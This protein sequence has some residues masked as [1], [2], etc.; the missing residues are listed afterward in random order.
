MTRELSDFT[1]QQDTAG[2]E[3]PGPNYHLPPGRYDEMCG[4]GGSFR[5][6]WR[7]LGAALRDLGHEA[8]LQRARQARRLLRE[9]G[10]TYNVY[11]DP[12]GQSRIWELDPVPMVI[13]SRE[14]SQIESGLMQRA[15]LLD[16]ILA[17]IYG[18]RTLLERG[19]IPPELVFAHPGFLRPCHG[20]EPAGGRRLLLYAADLVRDPGGR[21]TVV[22]DRTQAPSGAGYALENRTV[23]SS[24]LPSL[25][26][27]AQVHRL[28][29]FFQHYRNALAELA[30]NCANEPSI[31]VLTP[32]AR[33]EAYFEHAY[34]AGYL[35]YTL[36][37][38]E[39]LMVGQSQLLLMSPSGPQR[40]DV[41]LR[42]VDD[43]FCDPLELRQESRLGVPGLLQLARA[44]QVGIGNALG[45]SFLENPGLLP[46]LPGIATALL[47][48]D[49]RLPSAATWWCG[50]ARER[51][52]V[53]ANL[54]TL[55]LKRVHRLPGEYPT[56]GW[57]LSRGEAERWK[58]QI[59]AK[60]YLYVG[61]ERLDLSTTPGLGS[62]CLVPQ[63]LI[64]RAFAV[65]YRD[66]HQVMPGGLARVAQNLDDVIV[67]SQAGGAS[68]DTWVVASEP[69]RAVAVE[70][71]RR[72]PFSSGTERNLPSRSADNL[73][74]VGRYCERAEGVARALR[75]VLQLAKEAEE[76]G[77]D[78][79]RICL[80]RLLSAVTHL[81]CTYPGFLS[82]RAAGVAQA[83]DAEI[84]RVALDADVPGSLAAT[85]RSMVAAAYEVRDYWSA[86]A[87]R[88]VDGVEEHWQ[89]VV[90]SRPAAGD[91][92][93]LELNHLI[94]ALVGF[95]GL[96]HESMVRDQGWLFLHLGRKLE[97][98]QTVATL[99]R[100]CLAVEGD[101]E[102]EALISEHVLIA[103]D[104]LAAFRRADGKG[105]TIE[106]VLETVL[107]DRRNPRSMRYQTERIR[108]AVD[109]LPGSNEGFTL[110][111]KQRIAIELDT[112]LSLADPLAL[113]R[114][115]EPPALRGTLSNLLSESS[116]KLAAL[117]R[118]ITDEFF[119]QPA[120]P[121]QLVDSTRQS[122]Q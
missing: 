13:E 59:R 96:A 26:R 37:R 63:P 46:F 52:Y 70:I 30:P 91:G 58:E 11:G 42:R 94:S 16:R 65:G 83:R 81:T 121:H 40:V 73:F 69:E 92:L 85:V 44:R 60:P 105:E 2:K 50:Q 39:D 95:A 1:D 14:W 78:A 103:A 104:S 75:A 64:L 122:R 35:G 43:E 45:S 101:P 84:Q 4:P 118:E 12:R 29:M 100:A 120:E 17:D 71:P 53:I 57:T 108:R 114:V 31:A 80:E 36:V 47:G 15:E 48:Q 62:E 99:G 55:V 21:W 102:V 112:E 89:S 61:Q 25:F 3:S 28:A 33:N 5:A 111:A 54:R 76:F 51:E 49:L 22:S 23:V 34:L 10:V 68:K 115:E 66:G 86:D 107:L 87:W 119:R 93:R 56:M 8:L 82:G 106:Q 9:N 38:G 109:E 117:S 72:Q 113:A 7:Y 116:N 32:G 27:D 67:S 74:W 97:R 77:A 24:V 79:H 18:P 110:T 20:V 41:V 90:T 6:H 19:L 88:L 98:A